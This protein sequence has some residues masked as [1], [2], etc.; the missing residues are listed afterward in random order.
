L[1]TRLLLV[2]ADPGLQREGAAAAKRLGT[3]MDVLPT[4]EAALSWMLRPDQLCTH[5]LVPA[6]MDPRRLDAL[7]GMVDEVTS[8]PTPLLLLGGTDDQGPLVL[9][10]EHS[11]FAAIEQTLRDYR[12]FV[13][14]IM[15]ALTAAELRTALHSGML[16]MRFQ[17]ILDAASLEPIGMEALARLHHPTLGI[18]RPKDF[19]PQAALSGQERT[20]T[21]IVAARAMLELRNL[22]G[23]PERNFSLNVPLISLCHPYAVERARELCAVV[24]VAPDCIV[25]EALETE[26]E[27]DMRVLGEAVERWRAV[28]FLVTIDDAG[29]RL[30]HW[31]KLVDLP[32]TGLKLDSL[33]AADQPETNAEAAEIVTAAKA[34]GLFVTA[35]GIEDEAAMAR[36]RGLGVDALQGFLFCRPLPARALPIW[37]AEW[38][39]G[40]LPR[41]AAAA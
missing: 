36:M 10:V 23:L 7:A 39:A 13:P 5:V 37:L 4:L 33:L 40:L 2:T 8:R 35:E 20:L 6:S 12:P 15:P 24:D 21:G 22:G 9:A 28:G 25:I 14:E 27:P 1:T 30:K 38:R 11:A 26:A 41:P 34:R 32:F 29:P 19:M 17:P 18:L 31:R 3:P 16:R